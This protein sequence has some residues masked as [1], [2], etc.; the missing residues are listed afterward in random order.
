MSGSES[1]CSSSD[2]EVVGGGFSTGHGLGTS[3]FRR[4][5]D[6]GMPTSAKVHVGCDGDGSGKAKRRNVMRR[7]SKN[8][9]II[10]MVCL[11][12]VVLVLSRLTV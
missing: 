6:S 12:L 11:L 10:G 2:D 3:F 7:L 1:E 9:K 5:K 8:R 4:R